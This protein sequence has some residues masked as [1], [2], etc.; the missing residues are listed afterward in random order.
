MA[1]SA[2]HPGRRAWRAAVGL[3]GSLAAPAALA[4]DEVDLLERVEAGVADTSPLG[5]SLRLA[6]LDLRSP[7]GF[8]AVYRVRG[9]NGEDL[10]A[11][12]SGGLIA[13]FPVSIYAPGTR[14]PE[15]PPGTVF[16]IGGLP[17]TFLSQQPSV[18]LVAPIGGVTSGPLGVG[19]DLSASPGESASGRRA[20]AADARAAAGVRGAARVPWSI[21]SSDEYRRRRIADLCGVSAAERAQAEGTIK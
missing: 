14:A 20:D 18:E 19:V 16:Y 8:D 4:Q 1:S 10:F 11:R 21:W 15:I 3:A 17:S 13:V 2:R 5:E 9:S 7:L 12:A 6:P